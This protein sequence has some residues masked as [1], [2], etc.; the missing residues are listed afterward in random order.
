MRYGKSTAEKVKEY[1]NWLEAAKVGYKH[2]AW[3]PVRLTD[4]TYVWLEY[5]WAYYEAPSWTYAGWWAY[6]PLKE[7]E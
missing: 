4:G 6:R 7:D 5:V 1:Q 3:W 2:F